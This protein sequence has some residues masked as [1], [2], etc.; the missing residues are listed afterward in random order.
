MIVSNNIQTIVERSLFRSIL[1]VLVSK[2]Y[3]PN[4]ALYDNSASGKAALEA[5]KQSIASDK[6][7]CITLN[8]ASTNTD[9][10]LKKVPSISI[11]TESIIPDE[12]GLG[13]QEF[14][15]EDGGT[16]SKV[17]LPEL[18]SKMLMEV[19]VV[20]NTT[21]Q[22]RICN[23]VVFEALGRRRPVPYIED[24][25]NLFWLIMTA[26]ITNRNLQKGL[27]ERLYRY[28]ALDI[29]DYQYNILRTGI[30]PI[31]EI[32]TEIHTPIEQPTTHLLNN[33]FTVS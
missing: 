18:Y 33:D 23:E 12:V 22:D 20:A 25:E 32:S 11:L 29:M 26:S 16:F 21:A 7:F 24:E 9:I 1:T 4:P 17:E 28:E 2:G 6:G 27:L 3:T 8:G 5:A 31:R 30:A 15:P 13:G 14:L 10:G 19:R